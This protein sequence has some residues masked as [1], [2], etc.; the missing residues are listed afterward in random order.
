MFARQCAVV[1]LLLLVTG[2]ESVRADFF[3]YTDG[4]GTVVIVDDA[5]KI[6][7]RYRHRIKSTEVAV[8]NGSRRTGV[9]I[10]K[11]RVFV[12]VTLNYRG[13]TAEVTL[14]LDTGA[15]TTVISTD[16]ADRLGISPDQTEVRHAQVADGR[17]LETYRTILESLSVGPKVKHDLEVNIM[18]MSGP[19]FGADGL[20]GMN[21]LG[22]FPYHLDLNAQSINW[23][24]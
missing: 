24:K 17:I 13:R 20:L 19:S 22:D 11:N 6:P 21:F 3:Q 12:P 7:P 14:L 16:V 9:S 2:I 5:S 8:E 4:G 1:V 10:R 18:P 23:M 15:S